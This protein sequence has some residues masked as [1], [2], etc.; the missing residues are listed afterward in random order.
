MMLL[1]LCKCTTV[2]KNTLGVKSD[3]AKKTDAATKRTDMRVWAM[4]MQL[5][6]TLP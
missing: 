6:Y 3:M 2:N 5:Q 4:L 1:V